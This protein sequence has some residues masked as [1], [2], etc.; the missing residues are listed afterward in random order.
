M[1]YASI[2]TYLRVLGSGRRL[3]WGLLGGGVEDAAATAARGP[4]LAKSLVL[5]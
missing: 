5:H 4:L 2:H 3:V 1:A